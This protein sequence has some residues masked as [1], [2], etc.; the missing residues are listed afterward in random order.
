M[1][2]KP[3]NSPPGLLVAYPPK[4]AHHAGE[5]N[6]ESAM[7]RPRVT[8]IEPDED[9]DSGYNEPPKRRRT[10]RKNM[11]EQKIE[12]WANSTFIKIAQPFLMMLMSVIITAVGYLLSSA[13]D[14]LSDITASLNANRV[15]TATVD[16]RV[17]N[18]EKYRDEAIARGRV[19]SDKVLQLE[20]EQKMIKEQV[21]R[22]PNIR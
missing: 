15:T 19:L 14:Q 17:L 11:A 10:D 8:M 9:E 6:Q 20:F 16:M 18:I 5:P 22:Q 21:L 13:K 12:Q 2:E 3:Y 1:S 4:M 7:P